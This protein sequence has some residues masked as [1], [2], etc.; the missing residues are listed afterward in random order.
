MKKVNSVFVGVN[1]SN[2]ISRFADDER[3]SLPFL[4]RLLW[5]GRITNERERRTNLSGC[6][7]EC[8]AER[9]KVMFHDNGIA[10]RQTANTVRPTSTQMSIFFS[11]LKNNKRFCVE[12]VSLRQTEREREID[13]CEEL[14]G[15]RRESFLEFVDPMSSSVQIGI[16]CLIVPFAVSTLIIFVSKMF[17]GFAR[18]R[19]DL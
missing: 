2:D 1:T 18:R 6:W 7:N 10:T 8:Q 19:F 16:F 14:L 9:R 5:T 11:P 3:E 4:S 17:D 13:Y 12:L 15:R